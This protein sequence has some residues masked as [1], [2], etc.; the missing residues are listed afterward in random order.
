MAGLLTVLA[1]EVGKKLFPLRGGPLVALALVAALTATWLLAKRP[2]LQLWL[3]YLAPAPL[4]FVLLFV[5]VSPVASLVRAHG[6]AVPG[7]SGETRGQPTPPVV[8]V[9]FDEFP[10]ESLLDHR[11]RIDARMYP[12]FAR[13]AG[14]A[15]WYRNAT[16]VNWY[17]P[18]RCRPC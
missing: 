10:M 1:V 13:L 9:F 6:Q 11:G 17:T 14:H 3:R 2:E 4:V 7:A 8:M 16:G 18:T 12:N 5:F 15:I